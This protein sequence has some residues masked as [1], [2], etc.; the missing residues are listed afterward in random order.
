MCKSAGLKPMSMFVPIC[1]FIPVVLVTTGV[2][3]ISCCEREFDPTRLV[4]GFGH[5]GKPELELELEVN[6]GMGFVRFCSCSCLCIYSALVET[7]HDEDEAEVKALV[8]ALFDEDEAEV[9]GI[10]E[11]SD[12]KSCRIA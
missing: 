8:E 1:T 7:L 11:F 2:L 5:G 12:N 6:C 9:E 10:K 4:L 3:S